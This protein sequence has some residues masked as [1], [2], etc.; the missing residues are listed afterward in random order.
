MRPVVIV[1]HTPAFHNIFYSQILRDITGK[2]IPSAIEEYKI[3]EILDPRQADNLLNLI[4]NPQ[5]PS[6]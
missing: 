3:M 2:V 4:N 5:P 1:I 6:P